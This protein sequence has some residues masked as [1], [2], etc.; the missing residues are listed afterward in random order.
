MTIFQN[1]LILGESNSVIHN[2]WVAGFSSTLA[3]E[4]KVI[5]ESIGST[6][7][8]NSI[9]VLSEYSSDSIDLV[10]LDSFINDSKFF[11]DDPILYRGLLRSVFSELSAKYSCSILYLCFGGVA[12]LCSKKRNLKNILIQESENFGVAFFDVN[13]FLVEFSL[14]KKVDF[15]STYSDDAHPIPMY[16]YGMGIVLHDF[17]MQSNLDKAKSFIN[18]SG[19]F[20]VYSPGLD[21]ECTKSPNFNCGKIKNSL[22]DLP[23]VSLN[24]ATPRLRFKPREGMFPL[25]FFLNSATS[26]G[27]VKIE[28]S[29]FILKNIGY[30]NYKG[31]GIVVWA[32]PFHN[33]IHPS[34]DGFY[35]LFPSFDLPYEQ[36]E[37]CNSIDTYSIDSSLDL[38]HLI[39][40]DFF[41]ILGE[42][43]A[44][45]SFSKVG[46]LHSDLLFYRYQSLNFFSMKNSIIRCLSNMKNLALYKSAKQSTLSAHSTYE[47]A[48]GGCN[49]FISGRFGFH[50]NFELNPWWILDLGA[51]IDLHF[52]VIYNRMDA[53]S[54]RANKL[55][56]FISSNGESWTLIYMNEGRGL[57]GGYDNDSYNPLLI[58]LPHRINAQFIKIDLPDE[59][60]LHL[61]E[62]EVY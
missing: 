32:R 18:Y 40:V 22:V 42:T 11:I 29:N 15:E 13:D 61:D 17:L 21:D 33:F 1:I 25:G 55:R 51:C 50:T 6:G 19:V 31:E 5:N 39:F 44:E 14:N 53:A 59:Q 56:V 4:V 10:V 23:V 47:G 24:S 49:G 16:S 20:Q 35:S 37:H 7:I 43:S 58:S 41:K 28:G 46:S 9:R 26:K 8:F 27:V 54:E 45:W 60:V 38:I 30:N 57:V 36:T 3:G 52:I 34:E 2:G 12:P 48:N 62:V